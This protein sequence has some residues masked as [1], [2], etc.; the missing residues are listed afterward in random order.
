MSPSLAAPR[1]PTISTWR[2]ATTKLVVAVLLALVALG[3]F[4]TA[5]S[6]S[7]SASANGV[8][9]TDAAGTVWLCR[10]GLSDDPCAGNLSTTVVT[11]SDKRTVKHAVATGNSKFDCFYLYPTASPEQTVNSDLTVQ[12]AETSNA[13]AQTAPF[14]DVCDVWAPMYRQITV[15][16]L[17]GGTAGPDASTIAYA[18]VLSAWKDFLAHYDKGRPIILI[19][20][21]QGSVNM[22]KLLQS[23]ADDNSSLRH[24]IVVAI[25]AGGNVTVPD[26]KEVGVTFQHLPVCTKAD[27]TS[28]VI[29][30]SSFPTEPPANSMFGRPGQGIS[31]NYGQT[32]TTGVHVVCVNPASIG[33][34]TGELAS[35]F[36]LAA[37]Q[38]LPAQVLPPPAVTTPWV[39]YPDMYSASCESSGGATWLQ[40]THNAPA[41]DVRPLPAE[42]LGP[43]FGYHLDDI[44][45]SMGNLVND[46]RAEEAAY[47]G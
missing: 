33:G 12:P 38:P 29:A 32:Q 8:A 44:N 17:L 21:S 23:Q 39:T 9:R 19:S 4:S 14:S 34:G 10:P 1:I 15:K 36:P 5:A 13:M 16:A 22:I 6:A 7:V 28:C 40:I 3:S 26:G 31:L 2:T 47:K 20:H 46:V 18:S 42:P 27:Q 41:G 37:V 11:A 43:T 24:R 25:I 30:Y 45:L 35:S